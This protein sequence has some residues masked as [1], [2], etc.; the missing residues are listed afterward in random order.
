MR[1]K[2]TAL[3]TQID[4]EAKTYDGTREATTR[5]DAAAPAEPR[6]RVPDCAAVRR[7]W[8]SS[9][10]TSTKQLNERSGGEMLAMSDKAVPVRMKDYGIFQPTR[11]VRDAGAAGSFPSRTSTPGRY[12]AAIDRLRLHGLRV[13]TRRRRRPDRRPALRH[14]A[15]M[16]KS[17]RP[18]QGHR[19]ARLAG[20]YL[21]TRSCRRRQGRSSFRPTSRSRAWR[22]ICSKPRATTAW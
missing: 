20:K 13:Q 9:W 7:P 21:I 14:P 3:T 6:R 4:G 16:T 19:E 2:L 17:E 18:F 1:R 11:M 8:T 22:S 5:R 12:A 15:A 10:A